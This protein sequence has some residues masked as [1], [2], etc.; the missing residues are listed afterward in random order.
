MKNKKKCSA[1]IWIILK[2]AENKWKIQYFCL[3]NQDFFTFHD[4]L[5]V[6]S[7]MSRTILIYYLFNLFLCHLKISFNLVLNIFVQIMFLTLIGDGF[8]GFLGSFKL[9]VSEQF[10]ACSQGS[11]AEAG[12]Y[13]VWIWMYWGLELY[14]CP[15]ME[16]GDDY[17]K[18]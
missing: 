11:L 12:P 8:E 4:T 17:N 10:L 9:I 5:Y 6:R 1:N 13:S 15:R 14:N 18:I 16:L 7:L 3:I 2:E